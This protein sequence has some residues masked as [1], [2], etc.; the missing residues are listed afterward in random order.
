MDHAFDTPPDQAAGLRQLFGH[1]HARFVPVLAN[2]HVPSTGVLLERLCAACAE[3][4]LDTLLVDAAPGTASAPRE[5]AWLDLAEGI[6]PLAERTAFLAARGL[7]LRH[8]DAE[9]STALFLQAVADAAPR[10]DIVIVHA[11]APELARLFARRNVR[12]LLLA[13]DRPDSVTHAYAGMKLLAL[14]AGLMVHDL[15][16]AAAGASPRAERIAVHLG[17]CA[18]DFIG[19]LLHGWARL[20]PAADAAAMPPALRAFVRELLFANEPGAVPLPRGAGMRRHESAVA[21]AA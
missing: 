3:M 10:A 8:V 2:P 1:A 7:P 18:E 4:D 5:L 21:W 12:P 15:L 20:D 16:L 11:D 13:D 19:A 14:R 17:R 9:G 6:E